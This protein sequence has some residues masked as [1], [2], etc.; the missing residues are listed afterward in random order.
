MKSLPFSIPHISQDENTKIAISQKI[1]R[2]PMLAA[3]IHGFPV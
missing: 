1:T 3:G 2:C